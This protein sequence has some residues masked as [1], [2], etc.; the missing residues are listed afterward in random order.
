[1]TEIDRLIKKIISIERRIWSPISVSTEEE[2]KK[3]DENNL[4]KYL[5]ACEIVDEQSPIHIPV[6]KSCMK[7]KKFL[8]KIEE[9]EGV[10]KECK[11]ENWF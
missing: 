3:R 6:Y 9:K 4:K 1:M 5:R 2:L 8:G 7:C 11:G 10:C